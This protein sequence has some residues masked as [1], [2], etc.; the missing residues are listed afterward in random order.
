[1]ELEDTVFFKACQS[2]LTE[3]VNEILHRKMHILQNTLIN[4][5]SDEVD[6]KTILT[7][8][9]K[10]KKNIVVNLRPYQVKKQRVTRVVS[11][12]RRCMARIG[13]GTQ[14][15]RSRM[16]GGDFCKSHSN[17]LPYGRIDEDIPDKEFHTNKSKSNKQFTLNDLDESKYIKTIVVYMG[18]TKFSID[19]NMLIYS[20]T[21]IVGRQV[22]D[23]IEWYNG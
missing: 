23:M 5:L 7:I 2:M 12:E 15:S 1:M 9:N 13:L 11:S 19:S 18:D 22:D 10:Y 14:C 6:R 17:S 16:S 8:V 3:R 4:N 20:G 21:D